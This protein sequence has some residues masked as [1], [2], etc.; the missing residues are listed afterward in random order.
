M[1]DYKI[2]LRGNSYKKR[3]PLYASKEGV[4]ALTLKVVR[5]SYSSEKACMIYREL[6]YI[7][8]RVSKGNPNTLIDNVFGLFFI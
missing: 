4:G 8:V 7:I 6:V 1:E 2:N 3:I 5:W